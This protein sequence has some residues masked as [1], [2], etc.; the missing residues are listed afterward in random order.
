MTDSPFEPGL[1]VFGVMKCGTNFDSVN[2]HFEVQNLLELQ[3]WSE[4]FDVTDAQI[5]LKR[6]SPNGDTFTYDLIYDVISGY[7]NSNIETKPGDRWEYQCVKDTF[8]VTASCLVPNLPV[9]TNASVEGN[10]IKF[11]VEADTS[12]FIYL[13]YV[14]HGENILTEYKIPQVGSTTEWS[15]QTTWEISSEP[16]LL[17][18]CAYDQNLREYQTTSNTFFKPNAFRPA[19]STVDGGYGTFGAIAISRVSIQP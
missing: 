9:I 19:F 13:A 10:A 11:T 18:V 12:A 2:Y 16:V 3:D 1:N 15:I 5:Q 17:Y 14:L 7:G 8:K 6:M 4:G